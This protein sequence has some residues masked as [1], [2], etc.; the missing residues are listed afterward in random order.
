MKIKV[1]YDTE[2]DG[3]VLALEAADLIVMGYTPIEVVCHDE[4]CDAIYVI[5]DVEKYKFTKWINQKS[6]WCYF[7]ITTE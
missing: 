2:S 6:N 3:E 1:A 5:P 4:G 7:E